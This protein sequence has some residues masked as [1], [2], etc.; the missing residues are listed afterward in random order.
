MVGRW[1]DQWPWPDRFHYECAD[2]RPVEWRSSWWVRRSSCVQHVRAV[3]C[4]EDLPGH[5]RPP[6]PPG[7]SHT[8]YSAESARDH[9]PASASPPLRP[10]F[11]VYL[12]QCQNTPQVRPINQQRYVK[13]IITFTSNRDADLYAIWCWI[14]SL[15]KRDNIYHHCRFLRFSLSW[16][17]RF[18]RYCLSFTFICVIAKNVSQVYKINKSE[19]VYF[20]ER[21]SYWFYMCWITVIILIICTVKHNYLS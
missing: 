17:L 3:W 15:I 18:L 2:S 20:R 6:W 5:P 7:S 11:R 1:S 14:N 10:L 13:L 12:C 8:P 21:S 9:V 4:M 19:N 16:S